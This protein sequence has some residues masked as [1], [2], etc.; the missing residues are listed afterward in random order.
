MNFAKIIN[1][2]AYCPKCSERNYKINHNNYKSYN[3]SKGKATLFNATCIC[4]N[5]VFQYLL[6]LSIKESIYFSDDIKN[7]FEIKD[8]K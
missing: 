2:K 8:D 5:E 1:N 3:T 4:C 6:K 7:I